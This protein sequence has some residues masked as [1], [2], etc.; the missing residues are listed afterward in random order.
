MVADG[1]EDRAAHDLK[2][3]ERFG[4]ARAFLGELAA[5]DLDHQEH[6]VEST[7]QVV[8][9]ERKVFALGLGG[10]FELTGL[11]VDEGDGALRAARSST[12]CSATASSALSVRPSWSVSSSM[13]TGRRS[14]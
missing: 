14:W 10:G 5:E 8:R 6:A 2:I 1:L 11:V 12:A 7:A 4:E 9:E 3:F 13:T